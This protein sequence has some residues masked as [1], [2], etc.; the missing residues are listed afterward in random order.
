ML[1]V[2]WVLEFERGRGEFIYKLGSVLDFARSPFHT[3]HPSI[4]H[5]KPPHGQTSPPTHAR[6]LSPIAFNFIF[7]VIFKDFSVFLRVKIALIS[8]L[9]PKVE[10]NYRGRS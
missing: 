8:C 2:E 7:G 10:I 9:N 6:A 3:Y 1:A 5:T 4:L